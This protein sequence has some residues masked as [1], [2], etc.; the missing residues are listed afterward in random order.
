LSEI[1]TVPKRPETGIF[2]DITISQV[3]FSS[4]LGISSL[5]TKEEALCVPV[6]VLVIVN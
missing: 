6:G 3:S 4:E 1:P 2:R 5:F